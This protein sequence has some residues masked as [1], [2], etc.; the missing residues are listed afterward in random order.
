MA[1]I[2]A[3]YIKHYSHFAD[4]TLQLKKWGKTRSFEIKPNF[5]AYL[6]YSLMSSNNSVQTVKSF[7]RQPGIAEQTST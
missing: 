2:K 7:W 6:Y 1:F 4:I 3:H 5:L